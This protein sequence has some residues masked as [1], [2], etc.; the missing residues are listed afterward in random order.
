[1]TTEL[2]KRVAKLVMIDAD[3]NYLLLQR[4]D[5]PTFPN[6]PDLP[7][8]TVEAGEVARDAMIREV[9]EEIGVTVGK[10][11]I[12]EVYAGTDY[13]RHGTHYTLYVTTVTERPDIHI[14]W[15]HS[16]YE[17]LPK[18]TFIQKVLGAKDTFMH[19]VGE[20]MS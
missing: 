4:S 2:T 9:Q 15:E 16:G 11:A 10:V 19:M 13:S 14:S 6:D 3:D 5:H 7:G 17:W 8:G 20:V 18:E 12:T 1:M